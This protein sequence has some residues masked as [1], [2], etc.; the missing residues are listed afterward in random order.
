[1]GAA[2]F[3]LERQDVSAA[4]AFGRLLH[5]GEPFA[6]TL[7]RTY[8]VP[9]EPVV[10]IP[11][12]VHRCTRTRFIRGQYDTY[13][14]HVF[15]HSRLL[16]HRGNYEHDSDGCILVGEEVGV[17]NGEKA[18]IHSGAAFDRFMELAANAPEFYLEVL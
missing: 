15:G 6:V 13:E 16:F 3:A 8:E 2:F 4:G 5:V 14:V 7:E 10:K 1:M 9:G 11:P 17:L 18:I 12:G